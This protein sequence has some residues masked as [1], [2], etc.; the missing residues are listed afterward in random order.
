MTDTPK[1]RA[2]RVSKYHPALRQTAEAL[3]SSRPREGFVFAGGPGKVRVK[4]TVGQ[5][6]RALTFLHHLIRAAEHRG[7]EIKPGAHSPFQAQYRRGE[8]VMADS[9]HSCAIALRTKT[10][11]IEKDDVDQDPFGFS[12]RFDY[13][14]TDTL[15]LEL[16]VIVGTREYRDGVRKKLEDRI[17]DVLQQIGEHFDQCVIRDAERIANA[18]RQL[19]EEARRAKERRSRALADERDR[20]ARQLITNWRDARDMRLL[21][22]DVQKRSDRTETAESWLGWLER[23]CDWIDPTTALDEVAFPTLR[24]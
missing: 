21:I 20:I 11:R 6:A 2:R 17:D 15:L 18:E 5:R 24:D 4:V 16:D 9:K 12:S 14:P 23:W 8:L 3:R 7:W 22:A 13:V 19:E 1:R 10:S